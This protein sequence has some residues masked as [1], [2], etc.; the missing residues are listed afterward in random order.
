[1][2]MHREGEAPGAVPNRDSFVNI[3]LPVHEA[4]AARRVLAINEQMRVRKQDHD[5]EQLYAVFADVGHVSK[6]V[7]DVAHRIASNPHIFALSVSNVRGPAGTQYLAGGQIR[8]VYSL[9]EI[10]PHHALRV[11]AISFAGRIAIGLCA[12]GDAIPEL[13]ELAKSVD[14]SLVELTGGVTPTRSAPG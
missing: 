11:S 7:F 6:H 14:R 5:A 2:S 13:S 8:E 10:A 12:D 3:D 4:D 1:V 9:A